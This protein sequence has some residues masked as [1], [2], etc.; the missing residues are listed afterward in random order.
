M[1]LVSFLNKQKLKKIVNNLGFLVGL[2]HS[3]PEC[4]AKYS[5]TETK[6]TRY[7]H[8][9]HKV[10]EGSKT[11]SG[12]PSTP[13]WLHANV[14]NKYTSMNEWLHATQSSLCSKYIST[15]RPSIHLS[16]VDIRLVFSYLLWLLRR[17]LLRV[18][19]QFFSIRKKRITMNIKK[20]NYIQAMSFLRGTC[21]NIC[22]FIHILDS[23]SMGR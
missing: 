20:F 15:D 10:L 4:I 22:P 11:P 13:I 21:E 17:R 18:Y 23:S 2:L 1:N 5:A 8:Q 7:T 14:Y 9:L 19:C 3:L 12:S 6:M 16:M